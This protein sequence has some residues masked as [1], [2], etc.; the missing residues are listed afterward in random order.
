MANIVNIRVCEYLLDSKSHWTTG[1]RITTES[2]DIVIDKFGKIVKEVYK[3]EDTCDK[4]CL[5]LD[6]TYDI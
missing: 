3:I 4:G 6:L 1:I 2:E 5:N